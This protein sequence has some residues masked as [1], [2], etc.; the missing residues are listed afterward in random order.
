MMTAHLQDNSRNLVSIQE[1]TELGKLGTPCL[2]NSVIYL[3]ALFFIKLSLTE[4][5]KEKWWFVFWINFHDFH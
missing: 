5:I 3:A 2:Y 4:A 1:T